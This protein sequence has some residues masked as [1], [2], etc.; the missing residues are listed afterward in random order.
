MPRPSNLRR[1]I[2]CL[3]AGLLLIATACEAEPSPRVPA[4]P[5]PTPTVSSPSPTPTPVPVGE[6]QQVFASGAA[7]GE[8]WVGW[9]AAD[10]EPHDYHL[11]WARVDEEYPDPSDAA[12]NA[13]MTVRSD[14]LTGLEPGA[15]YKLRVRARYAE[16]SGEG[17][18]RAGRWS[19]SVTARVSA[20]PLAPSGL[21]AVATHAGVELVWDEADDESISLYTVLRTCLLYTSPSP[22]DG[23]LSRMPSSA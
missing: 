10:P 1:G 6:V 19:Q 3:I 7:R 11:S 12:G 21:A 5:E 18:F 22:R 2:A 4:A 23:L 20:P 14:T 9:A 13:F 16:G 8:I 15:T 17:A